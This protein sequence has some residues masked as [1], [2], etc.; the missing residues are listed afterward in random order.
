[1]AEAGEKGH[2]LFHCRLSTRWSLLAK[3]LFWSAAGLELLLIGLVASSVPLLWMLL[4]TLPLLGLYLENEK[5]I[6]QRLIVAFLDELAVKHEL[7]KVP[8]AKTAERKPATPFEA[9]PQ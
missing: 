5:R 8:F 9:R 1:M 7:T 4:L 2:Q 3:V 6:L